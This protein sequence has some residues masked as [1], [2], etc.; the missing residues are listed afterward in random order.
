M[1]LTLVS[2]CSPISRRLHNII[3]NTPT[4]LYS[5]C[6]PDCVS[7]APQSTLNSVMGEW[8][9]LVLRAFQAPGSSKSP[10]SVVFR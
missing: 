7:A 4:P 9:A 10:W 6:R 5:C 8:A 3:A 1:H 2:R